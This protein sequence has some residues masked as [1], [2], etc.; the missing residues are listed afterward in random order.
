ML[1]S[2]AHHQMSLW[3]EKDNIG[4]NASALSVYVVR[5]DNTGVLVR[6]DNTGVLVRG[7]NTGVL[8]YFGIKMPVPS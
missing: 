2:H 4:F 1:C 8:V 6:G 3:G 5:G 7:D